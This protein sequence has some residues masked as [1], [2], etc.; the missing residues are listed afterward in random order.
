[1]RFSFNS[2]F[3]ASF[4]CFK[5]GDISQ[6]GSSSRCDVNVIVEMTSWGCLIGE[7]EVIVDS[8]QEVQ[9][10]SQEIDRLSQLLGFEPLDLTKMVNFKIDI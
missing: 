8:K 10:A 9:L 6:N 5:F 7:I 1:M 3:G 4:K 2:I